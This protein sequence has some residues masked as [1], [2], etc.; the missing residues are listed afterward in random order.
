MNE[1]RTPRLRPAT[2]I[3]M[4]FL[5][6]AP[7]L[8]TAAP[9]NQFTRSDLA[10]GSQNSVAIADFNHD[11]NGD[12]AFAFYTANITVRLGNGDGTFGPSTAVPTAGTQA[13]SVITA[14]VN[15]DGNADLLCSDQGSAKISIVLGVGNGTFSAPL[16]FTTSAFGSDIRTSDLNADGRADFVQTVTSG[17]VAR[18]GNGDGTFGPEVLTAVSGCAASADFMPGDFNE[19]GRPDL[20]VLNPCPLGHV[21]LL[22]GNGDGSFQAPMDTPVTGPFFCDVGDLNG[23]GHLDLAMSQNGGPILNVLLGRGDGTF[24]PPMPSTVGWDAAGVRI[25]DL[26]ADGFA[27]IAVSS[28]STS[29]VYLLGGHGDGTFDPSVGLATARAPYSLQAGDLKTDGRPD[30]VTPVVDIAPPVD[31]LTLLLNSTGPAIGSAPLVTAPDSVAATEGVALTILVTATDPDG[32]AIASLRDDVSLA[33]RTFTVNAQNTSGTYTWTPS[34]GTARPT[35]YYVV[36]TARNALIGQAIVRV[37]VSRPVTANAPVL[38]QPSD[39][40]LNETS[41]ADQTLTATDAD[42]DALTFTKTAGPAFMTVTTTT[43]GTGTATGN[44]HLAPGS[45]DAGTYTATV[46][47]TDYGLYDEKSFTITV[48]DVPG[49]PTLAPIANMTVYSGQ[50]ADQPISASDADG[51]AIT[52]TFTGPSF[53]TVTSNTQVGTTRTGNIHLAPS[54][55]YQGS[56]AAS[57]TASSNSQSDTRSFLINVFQPIDRAPVVTAPASVSGLTFTFMTFTVS[58]VDPDGDAIVSLTASPLPSGSTFTANAAHTSGTF[59]WTPTSAQTGFYSVTFVAS[60]AFSGS[61]TTSISVNAGTPPPAVTAPATVSGAENTPLSFVVTAVDA[62]ASL[63][64]LTAAGLPSGATFTVDPG[65]GS[66]TFSWIP[67]Y[68]QAG[69]YT[70][71]FTATNAAGLSSMAQTYIT[72]GNVDRPPVADAGPD[73]SGVVNVPLS[74]DGSGS[75][76]PD[77]TPLTYGWDFGDG[78]SGSGSPSSHTY[79]AVGTYTVTLTVASGGLSATDTAL[80]SVIAELSATAFTTGGNGSIALNSGKPYACVQIQPAGGFSVADVDLASIRM[81]YPTG[82]ANSIFAD[83]AK[84]AVS[85]DKNRDGV[86]EITAC[87]RKGDLRTLFAGLAAGSNPVTVDLRGNIVS[88]GG[89]HATVSLVVKSTGALAAMIAPNPLNPRAQLTFRTSKAGAVRIQMF[90]TQGRLVRTI[91]DQRVEPGEHAYAVEGRSAS[92]AALAS[93]V[94]LVRIGTE[95]D[96]EETMRITLLK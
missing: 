96:G 26:N 78:A 73:K 17:V 31:G 2:S 55:L 27:D 46:R 94:Y 80:A 76:D 90:D 43:A 37:F 75:F 59:A 1:L 9:F 65:F 79:T 66:G 63:T 89:F 32:E 87:F 42:G 12:L 29:G 40:T 21:S 50:T 24:Q 68:A 86:D 67:T 61:A 91:A 77:G 56:Y 84:T 4:L 64:S 53:M 54:F 71:R 93:G 81:I 5:L 34:F 69:S 45:S 48:I 23:D 6:A 52:F 33:G 60:N 58:A 22:I 85:G 49:A 35:P 41:A 74:F 20:A 19:D 95:H 11:G 30:L 62:D 16:S 83:P 14:D 47:A 82:S 70:V 57:V 8:A 18:L 39:M 3:A 10:V 28:H 15:G 88:G 44:V 7:A 38:T 51:D 36:F 72:I 92:G 25:A 13:Q